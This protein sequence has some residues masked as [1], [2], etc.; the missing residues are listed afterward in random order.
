MDMTLYNSMSGTVHNCVC[1]EILCVDTI[2]HRKT[3]NQS[4]CP[5]ACLNLST[6]CRYN[7]TPCPCVCLSTTCL[8]LYLSVHPSVSLQTLSL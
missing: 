6:D 2:R 8:F 5:S 4:V 3:E 1:R 7:T